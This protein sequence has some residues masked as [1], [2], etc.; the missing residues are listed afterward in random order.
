[1]KSWLM[2]PIVSAVIAI[3]VTSCGTSTTAGESNFRFLISDEPNAI[4]DFESLDVSISSIGLHE[5]GDGG[6]WITLEPQEDSVDLVLLQDEISQVL[7]SGDITEGR[8]DKVFINVDLVCGTLIESLEDTSLREDPQDGDCPEGSFEIK[9]PSNKLHLNEPFEVDRGTVT[10]YVYDMT[11]VKAG[12]EQSGFKYL[13]KPQVDQSGADVPF[14]E[15]DPTPPEITIS[16]V[17]DGQESSDPLTISFSATDNTDPDPDVS[18]T[19]NGDS[20]DSDTEVSD[21]GEYELVV[22]A[23][24]DSGNQS[25]ET[26]NFEIVGS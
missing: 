4:G 2:V 11:V 6:G 7:W 12:N 18:A 14:V 9:L 20:F 25:Q 10:N 13:I 24:D 21:V 22:T 1:M 5:D 26:V 16:G 8:Y 17:S 3:L 19:L 15:L 23:V